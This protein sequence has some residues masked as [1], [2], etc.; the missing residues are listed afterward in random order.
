MMSFVDSCAKIKK[1]YGANVIYVVSNDELFVQNIVKI[2]P[3]TLVIVATSNEQ[4]QEK[5]R[6]TGVKVKKIPRQYMPT[7]GAL[8]HIENLIVDAVVSDMIQD[9]E[10]VLFITKGITED[11]AFGVLITT[12]TK[13][14]GITKLRKDIEQRIDVHLM[15]AVLKLCLEIVEE[16]RENRNI[17]TIFVIGD[18]ENVMRYSRQLIINPFHGHD[19][20]VRSVY[21]VDS[22]ETLKEFAKLDGGFITDEKGTIIS[23]GRYFTVD[24]DVNLQSGLGSRHLAAAS[25]SKVTK[26]ISVVVSSSGII[27]VFMDGKSIFRMRAH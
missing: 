16:G 12:D 8:A 6:K 27:Q 10:K 7:I 25:I 23:A 21:D 2:S 4:L 5:L 20:S 14:I 18:V 11:D 9:D 19:E 3:P 1:E 15:D 22:W 13:N 24:L 26:A 17:G